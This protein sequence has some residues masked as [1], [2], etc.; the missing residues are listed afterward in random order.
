M[1]VSSGSIPTSLSLRVPKSRDRGR[2]RACPAGQDNGI[3]PRARAAR[4]VLTVGRLRTQRGTSAPKQ[5]AR[6]GVTLAAGDR[7]RPLSSLPDPPPVRAIRSGPRGRTDV[8]RPVVC[9]DGHRGR[10]RVDRASRSSPFFTRVGYR[11]VHRPRMT[12]A[13]SGASG[14]TVSRSAPR[15]PAT[16]APRVGISCRR[17]RR[18]LLQHIKDGVVRRLRTIRAVEHERIRVGLATLDEPTRGVDQTEDVEVPHVG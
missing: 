10:I 6:G 7:S 1:K 17:Q 16:A 14:A 2:G 9:P 15:G 3:L 8:C 12:S 11:G 4:G 18:P 13:D 5:V